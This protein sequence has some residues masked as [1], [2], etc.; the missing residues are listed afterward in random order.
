[1]DRH[2]DQTSGPNTPG[3]WRLR[4]KCGGSTG[5]EEL[6]LAV[7][8]PKLRSPPKTRGSSLGYLPI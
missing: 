4:S 8:R 7:D 1:M 6:A 3:F 2:E 5:D